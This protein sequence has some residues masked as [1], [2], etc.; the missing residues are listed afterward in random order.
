MGRKAKG[1]KTKVKP[2]RPPNISD[3]TFLKGVFIMAKTKQMMAMALAAAVA[4][5]AV[6]VDAQ[7]A[8]SYSAK[9]ARAQKKAAAS[10]NKKSE[11]FKKILESG[12]EVEVEKTVVAEGTA[13]LE[14]ETTG[15]NADKGD[16]SEV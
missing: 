16:T 3:Q 13:D 9:V 12:V 4:V 6:P 7:A 15:E 11:K 10:L 5:T 2:A 1:A 8:S 14:G